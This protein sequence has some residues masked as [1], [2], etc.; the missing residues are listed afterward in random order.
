MTKAKVKQRRK[1]RN[2]L[3]KAT[4]HARYGGHKPAGK[5][6]GSPRTAERPVD[7]VEVPQA[8]EGCPEAMTVAI[9]DARFPY[10]RFAN[11]PANNSRPHSGTIA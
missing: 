1:W 5:P 10:W 6:V 3:A 7:G 2:E 11:G 9:A 8:R 4:Q